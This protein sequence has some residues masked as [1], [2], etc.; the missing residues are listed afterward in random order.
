MFPNEADIPLELLPFEKKNKLVM[1][2]QQKNKKEFYKQQIMDFRKLSEMK[3]KF[4]N[5]GMKEH[6]RYTNPNA[7]NLSKVKMWSLQKNNLPLI[8][9]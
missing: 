3:G 5:E 7:I 8:G 1:Q 4:L 9:T 2:V 6:P